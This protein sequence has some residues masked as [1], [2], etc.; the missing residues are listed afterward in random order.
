[1]RRSVFITRFYSAIQQRAALPIVRKLHNYAIAK[2][3]TAALCAVGVAGGAIGLRAAYRY[4]RK[5][6]SE[7]PSFFDKLDSYYGFHENS[8]LYPQLYRKTIK[9]AFKDKGFKSE[10]FKIFYTDIMPYFGGWISNGLLTSLFLHSIPLVELHKNGLRL[11]LLKSFDV[12]SNIKDETIVVGLVAKLPIYYDSSGYIEIFDRLATNIK[13]NVVRKEMIIAGLRNKYYSD[14]S[15]YQTLID[16]ISDKKLLEEIVEE[17][18]LH[19]STNLFGLIKRIIRKRKINA[20]YSGHTSNY[21]DFMWLAKRNLIDSEYVTDYMLSAL[22]SKD[23]DE[24]KIK[25][26]MEYLMK[27]NPLSE[28]SRQKIILKEFATHQ[29]NASWDCSRLEP[30]IESI[31]D[32]NLLEEIMVTAKKCPVSNGV[33]SVVKK[34]IMKRRIDGNYSKNI[35]NF[36]N[37]AWLAERDLIDSS[38]VVDYFNTVLRG[39]DFQESDQKEILRYLIKLNPLA[40][41]EI[42][43]GILEV[44][45]LTN[46]VEKRRFLSGM[47]KDIGYKFT[48]E[49]RKELFHQIY[50][51]MG[52]L[53]YTASRVA[54]K[55]F[56]EYIRTEHPEIDL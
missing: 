48:K 31:D 40:R 10:F 21:H 19:P 2:P 25:E 13:S 30:L 53:R 9:Y 7:L 47:I 34:I 46:N 49:E 39:K 20:N 23:F 22:R 42:S 35:V 27:L 4:T 44:M 37:F 55:S 24:G 36:D 43:I 56:I 8:Y 6:E 16:G 3:K 12:L 5:E 38:D 11:K 14:F 50:V 28:V 26:I 17:I 33:F 52:Q 15:V 29:W 32:P 54:A 51:G 1:M 18:N 45:G 41:R